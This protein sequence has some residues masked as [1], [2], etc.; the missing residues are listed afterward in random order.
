MIGDLMHP[1]LC[2]QRMDGAADL[3]ARELLDDQAKG[4]ISLAHDRVEMGGSHPG[5]VQLL[6]GTA[7]VHALMLTDIA[8]EQ[9][10]VVGPEAMEERVELGRAGEARFVQDVEMLLEGF[11]SLLIDA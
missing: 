2:L 5:L 11:P 3:A 6:K 1:L 9:E 8:D 4:W 10:P 7:G